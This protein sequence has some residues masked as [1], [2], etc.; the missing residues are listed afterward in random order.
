[1]T[2]PPKK[3]KRDN[4]KTKETENHKLNS[5][6]IKDKEKREIQDPLCNHRLRKSPLSEFDV[7]FCFSNSVQNTKKNSKVVRIRSYILSLALALSIHNKLH[8][9]PVDVGLFT[10]LF[11]W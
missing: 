8:C 3:R 1:M 11:Y 7:T 2:N 10:N 5:E 9:I 6:S 4:I